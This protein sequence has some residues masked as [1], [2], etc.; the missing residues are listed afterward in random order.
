MEFNTKKKRELIE[1]QS[2]HTTTV[3]ATE[4]T[5][6]GG[7]F[8][9]TITV[10]TPSGE[11]KS[12]VGSTLPSNINGL[13][14]DGGG[15]AIIN[16]GTYRLTFHSSNYKGHGAPSYHVLTWDYSGNIPCTR[17]AYTDTYG[18]TADGILIHQ[19]EI[20]GNWSTGCITILGKDNMIEFSRMLNGQD[21][22]FTLIR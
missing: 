5:E 22:I 6:N 21:A 15:Y 3:V 12:F 10:T 14:A 7:K 8:N 19:A 1:L 9:A 18:K 16:P 4:G 20:N 17:S 11:T 2:T 13:Y